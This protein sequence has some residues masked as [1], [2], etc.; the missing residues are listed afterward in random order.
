MAARDT[1]RTA[2]TEEKASNA[3]RQA[4]DAEAQAER[5]RALLEEAIAQSG[6]LRA[7]LD[8]LERES[9]EEPARTSKS[10]DENANAA[11]PKKAAPKVKNR[12][13]VKKKE[14]TNGGAP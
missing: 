5:A 14:K 1:L 9:K 8:K 2:A 10:A 12:G 11:K 7:E 13:V 3:R 6:R 4:N